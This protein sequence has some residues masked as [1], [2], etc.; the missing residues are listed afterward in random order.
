[1]VLGP[2]SASLQVGLVEGRGQTVASLPTLPP[3]PVWPSSQCGTDDCG[4]NLSFLEGHRMRGST[5]ALMAFVLRMWH[6]WNQPWSLP[7]GRLWWRD[8]C[9]SWLVLLPSEVSCPPRSL[10]AE[11]PGTIFAYFW[12]GYVRIFHEMKTQVTAGSGNFISLLHFY[13]VNHLT[14]E[15]IGLTIHRI[16]QVGKGKASYFILMRDLSCCW[17]LWRPLSDLTFLRLN[18]SY[19]QR[20]GMVRKKVWWTGSW[21]LVQLWNQLVTSWMTLSSSPL[22]II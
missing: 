5:S 21:Q 2:A 13:I 6:P 20:W 17:P 10:P 15:F 19:D 3:T 7:Q 1:M 9:L 18:T 14:Q 8:C 12:G 16:V 22:R 11:M 4:G